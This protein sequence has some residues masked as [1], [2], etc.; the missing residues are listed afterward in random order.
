VI[1]ATVLRTEGLLAVELRRRELGLCT[2][3]GSFESSQE[4]RY[5]RVECFGIVSNNASIA[6]GRL[7]QLT[8]RCKD[9]IQAR[10]ELRMSPQCRRSQNCG[11][12]NRGRGDWER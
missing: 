5:A 8:P 1:V 12:M 2:R 4:S 10:D 9:K 7:D 11:F 3:H 6:A